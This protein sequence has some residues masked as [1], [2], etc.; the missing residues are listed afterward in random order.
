MRLQSG[1]DEVLALGDQVEVERVLFQKCLAK[2]VLS[3]D[4]GHVKG[5]EPLESR[6]SQVF[7]EQADKQPLISLKLCEVSAICPQ[8]RNGTALTNVFV[9]LREMEVRWEYCL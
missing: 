2:V 7:L 3:F 5:S 4:C 8:M 9:K 6:A 1:Y